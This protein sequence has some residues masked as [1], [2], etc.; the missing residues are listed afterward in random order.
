MFLVLEI[1][2]YLLVLSF[3]TSLYIFNRFAQLPLI[4]QSVG[5]VGGC[6][7]W[8]FSSLL[9][10]RCLYRHYPWNIP[11]VGFNLFLWVA[12][13]WSFDPAQSIRYTLVFTT[14]SIW[15]MILSSYPFKKKHLLILVACLFL[16]AVWQGVTLIAPRTPAYLKAFSAGILHG[17]AILFR[18]LGL[19]GLKSSVGGANS[20]GGLYAV[21]LTLLLPLSVFGFTWRKEDAWNK[22]VGMLIIKSVF[23]LGMVIFG[24]VILMSGSRGSYI[25]AISAVLFILLSRQNWVVTTFFLL[26]GVVSTFIP[27]IRF[28]IKAMYSGLVDQFRYTIWQNSWEIAKLVPLTGVGLGNFKPVYSFLF[29]ENYWHAHNI[30]INVLVELG[31]PGLIGFLWVAGA[32]IYYGLQQVNTQ[33]DSFWKNLELGLT[34]TVFGYLMRCLVDYTI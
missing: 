19:H 1:L 10:K 21:L 20:V 34:A 7:V 31:F 24:V 26:I 16:A 5:L 30:F 27:T 9:Q 22:K 4:M 14:G 6:L 23:I 25:G 12:C 18:T 2:S 17:D 33:P 15:L 11:V 29:Q 28:G 8:G 3:L 13:I 32:L